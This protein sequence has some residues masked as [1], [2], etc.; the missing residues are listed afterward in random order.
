MEVVETMKDGGFPATFAYDEC[1]IIWTD[2]STYPLSIVI[3]MQI[4]GHMNW[5]EELCNLNKIVL[6]TMSP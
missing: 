2:F 5:Q 1:N 6:G 4:R 3:G